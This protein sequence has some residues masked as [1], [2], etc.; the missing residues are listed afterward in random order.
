MSIRD[1][2][3][4]RRY[5]L[6]V[7]AVTVFVTVHAQES[8]EF[9]PVEYPSAYHVELNRVYTTVGAW[10]GK[11]DLYYPTYSTKSVPVVI[12]IHGGA[13]SHGVKESQRGF[14]TFFKNGWAVVNMEYRMSGTAPAPAAIE[15]ARCALI[16]INQH[17]KELHADVNRIVIMGGSAGGHL[18][19]MAGFLGN[20]HRF[21]VNCSGV[22]DV[23][24]AAV[25]DKYGVTDISL[26]KKLM[27][28]ASGRAWLSEKV[29]DQEFLNAISPINYVTKK[30]PP[31]FIVHGDADPTVPYQ[32]SVD[33]KKKLDDAGVKNVFITVENGVHGKFSKE[34][35]S[36]ISD[37]MWEFFKG[38]GLGK[39]Q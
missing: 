18:A 24:V 35:N 14:G 11:M 8:E 13:W 2:V 22:Q 16:Y 19:L 9:A 3:I 29:N 25:V 20:D 6:I 1:S 5:S 10:E 7:F 26:A 34:K 30:S 37:A 38:I 12:N 27:K 21:D 23:K 32:Q 33:L 4:M 39:V 36:E 28:S 17:A 15:D 31:V